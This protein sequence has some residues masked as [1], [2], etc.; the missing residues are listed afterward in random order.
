[1]YI[2]LSLFEAW[3]FCLLQPP[4]PFSGAILPLLRPARVGAGQAGK[5]SFI[6]APP[7]VAP[8]EH[9]VLP[10]H[11]SGTR[12]Q[13]T[14]LPKL[15]HR[16]AAGVASPLLGQQSPAEK[17]SA[18]LGQHPEGKPARSTASR[19]EFLLLPHRAIAPALPDQQRLW[20][21]RRCL[22]LFLVP[23]SPRSSSAFRQTQRSPF[24]G[25]R[26]RFVPSAIG[27]SLGISYIS[28]ARRSNY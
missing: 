13:V 9:T 27:I 2:H 22:Q 19:E 17:G 25:P 21:I 26:Q 6:R 8:R 24:P 18:C 12:A 14:V 3:R 16:M 7:A 15:T 4:A 11:H 10:Y 1:M 20:V 28:V 5:P 23:A